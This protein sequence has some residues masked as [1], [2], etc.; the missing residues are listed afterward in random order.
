M[1]SRVS[2]VLWLAIAAVLLQPYPV[3]ATACNGGGCWNGLVEVIK[4]SDNGKIWFVVDNSAALGNLTPADGCILKSV[5]VGAAEQALFI[6]VDDP[7][8]DE[9]Y[10]LLLAS[11]TLGKRISFN[12]ELDPTSGWCRLGGI[13]IGTT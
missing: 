8:R 10:K 9:K 12:P 4:I 1:K 13:Y 3:F 7:S 11:Q 2:F 6:A 5:W